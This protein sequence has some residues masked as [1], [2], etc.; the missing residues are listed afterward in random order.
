MKNLVTG[1]AGFLGTNLTKKLI[2]N[3]EEVICVD[4]FLTSQKENISSLI[5]NKNFKFIH[6]NI[7]KPLDIEIDRIWHL[8]CP[9]S[10]IHYLRDPIETSKI[11]FHGTYNLLKLAQAKNASFLF[12]S[13]SEIYGESNNHPQVESKIGS[14]NPIGKRSCYREGKRFAES[15]CYDFYRNYQ[16]D[17]RIARIFNTYGPNMLKKDGRVI[18]NFIDQALNNKSITICG[19]GL[20]TRSFCFVDDLII[21]LIKLMESNYKEPINLGNNKEITILKLAEIIKN[22]VNPNTL[23]INIPIPE[24]DLKRRNPNIKLARDLLDWEPKVNLDSGLDITID[25][26]KR[27]RGN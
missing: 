18:S 5:S 25:Y 1:G 14:V 15:L 12:A 4:N 27:I 24:D 22:K 17:I 8:A 21:G 11:I 26:F 19:N 23:L 3:G 6:H 2:E 10:P 13:S 20:Q 16:T 9:A 7:I